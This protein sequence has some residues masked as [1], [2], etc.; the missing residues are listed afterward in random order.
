MAL[1]GE[2]PLGNESSVHAAFVTEF[3]TT[4]DA[5]RPNAIARGR[6]PQAASVTLEYRHRGTIDDV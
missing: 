3:A 6:F 5:G 4:A 2:D 1:N